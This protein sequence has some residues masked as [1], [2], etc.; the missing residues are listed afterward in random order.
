MLRKPDLVAHLRVEH[1]H[2]SGVV[3][4]R[5]KLMRTSTWR[6]MRP[7]KECLTWRRQKISRHQ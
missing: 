4:W 1:S 5:D 7:R 2:K 3:V 6:E